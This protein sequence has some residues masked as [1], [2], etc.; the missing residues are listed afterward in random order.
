MDPRAGQAYNGL[1]HQVSNQRHPVHLV[2]LRQRPPI[3]Y[4]AL[5]HSPIRLRKPKELP[6]ALNNERGSSCR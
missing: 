1:S 3:D 5:L 2:F 4:S 6:M